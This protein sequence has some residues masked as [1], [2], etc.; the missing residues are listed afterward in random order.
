[1][2]GVAWIVGAYVAWGVWGENPDTK[3]ILG[4]A[5]WIMANQ[6]EL[7]RLLEGEVK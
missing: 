7:R 2:L 3:L 1:M 6:Y 4:F 5:C